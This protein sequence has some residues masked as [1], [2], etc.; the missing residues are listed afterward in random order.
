MLKLLK[1]GLKCHLYK[2]EE[3]GVQ[4]GAISICETGLSSVSPGVVRFIYTNG[5]LWQEK[6]RVAGYLWWSYLILW[7]SATNKLHT[8]QE[9]L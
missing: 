9:T 8:V 5:G 4:F 2:S 1:S 6:Y 3:R 7:L